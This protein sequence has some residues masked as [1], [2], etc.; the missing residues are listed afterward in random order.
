MKV[1]GFTIIR[2]GCEYDFPFEESI[3][4]LFPVVDE[5]VVNVGQGTDETLSRIEKL[6]T[7]LGRDKFVIFESNW[8][9]EDESNRRGGLILSEQT[10]QALARCTGDW[11]VYLQ[12]D[13]ALSEKDYSKLKTQLLRAHHEKTLEALVFDYIHFYGSYDVVQT[14]RSA[15]RREI[16]AIKNHIGIKSVGDAQSF[17]SKDG[18]KL[19]AV[20]AYT[21]IYHYGWVRSPEKMKEKTFFMDQLYHGAPSEEQIKNKTPHT[22]ENYKYKRILGLERFYG[23]HPEVMKKRIS[24][25]NWNWDFEG[26]PQIFSPSDTKKLILDK[27]EKITGER[28]FE[29]KNYLL[30]DLSPPQVSVILSTFRMTKQL[31]M[32]LE[33]LS[34]QTYRQFEV[35]LCEDDENVET[36]EVVKK[37]KRTHPEV[38]LKH[39]TQKNQGFRKC[40]ILNQGIIQSSGDLLVF[41]DGD[42]VV[43]PGF[44]NDHAKNYEPGFYLAGRRI[45][46]EETV[47]K[48]LNVESV[49]KGFF[50][51]I[52]LDWIIA[53]MNSQSDKLHRMLRVES[54]LLRKLLQLN[55]VTDLKGCNFSV[56]KTD[57][58]AINGFD[59]SYE[60]Y[61]R[62]DTDVELRLKNLGL[63]IKSLR[64]LALQ[65]HLWHPRREFTQMNESLLESVKKEKRIEAIK[66]LSNLRSAL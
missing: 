19:S 47:T 53:R 51:Y 32:V 44:I 48:K 58:L 24:E 36:N 8:G 20:L 43:H 34:R 1:S 31:E 52:N 17:R 65:F 56:S 21:S 55:K 11:C 46:L 54:P 39:I 6:A 4:S 62:E 60:G 50:D 59:E 23:S 63:K 13:E 14:S 35:I 66:G 12:A 41:L 29:K 37:F 33:S 61:G 18:S 42:C 38:N 2:N 27:I 25:K 9:F 30:R 3:R 10:N 49:K 45:D 57:I 26:S 64:G 15:Y 5:L 7:E 16:R 28:L 22:G 40:R